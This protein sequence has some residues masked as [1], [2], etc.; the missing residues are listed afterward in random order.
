MRLL[1]SKYNA[2]AGRLREWFAGLEASPE[3]RALED[4][5]AYVGYRPMSKVSEPFSMIPRSVEG[6]VV[7]AQERVARFYSDV[8]GIDN[9]V[10][11]ELGLTREELGNRLTAEQ[12]DAVGMVLEA[13]SRGRGFLLGDSTGIGKG[14]TL[15]AIAPGAFAQ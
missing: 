7:R 14:R 10:A 5:E 8:G 2:R 9:G 6:A 15:Q 1:P 11:R 4:S 12:V 3:E 13:A